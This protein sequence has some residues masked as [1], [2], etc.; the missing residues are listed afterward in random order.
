MMTIIYMNLDMNVIKSAQIIPIKQKD[1]TVTI[2]TTRN[3]KNSSSTNLAK[4][5]LG[6]CEKKIKDEY[7]VPESKSL[8]I[9]KIDVKQNGLRIPKI[10][11]EFIIH[12]FVII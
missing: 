1:Y 5:N 12:Y 10:A 11:Y 2:S 7:G 9:L 6:E 4:I 3:Q 8:Y